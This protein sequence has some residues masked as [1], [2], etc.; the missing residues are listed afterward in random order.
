[1]FS[2]QDLWPAICIHIGMILLITPSSRG[3]ECAESILA[4]TG[5]ITHFASTLNEAV[6]HLRSTEYGA[7][8]L[9]ECLLDSDPDQAQLV[10]QHIGN[11]TPVY[12]NCAIAGTDRLVREVRSA[13]RRREKE[14]RT[15]LQAAEETL[16]SD[17]REPLTAILLE[18]EMLLATPNLPPHLELK[19]RVIDDLAH[20]LND[21]LRT[22]D[23]ETTAS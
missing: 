16:S 15:A 11:A 10:L 14:R 3:H 7:I 22:R 8:V 21:R 9:D 17:L 5:Q 1:L 4:A 20:R 2:I 18:C 13:L 19:L 23:L 6:T 12:V